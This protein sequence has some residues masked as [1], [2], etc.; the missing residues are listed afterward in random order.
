[1]DRQRQTNRGTVFSYSSSEDEHEQNLPGSL[2]R[3]TRAISSNFSQS[4]VSAPGMEYTSVSLLIEEMGSLRNQLENQT[5]ELEQVSGYM[6]KS[7][8]D[9]IIT[10]WFLF[11]ELEIMNDLVTKTEILVSYVALGWS[12]PWLAHEYDKRVESWN[13]VHPLN[14]KSWLALTSK[15][16]RR[17]FNFNPICKSFIYWHLKY[18]VPRRTICL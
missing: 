9:F 12:G 1:M 11:P 10:V 15:D 4:P 2:E 5:M 14:L 18:R 17:P 6:K 8:W 16:E 13:T 3:S 7:S